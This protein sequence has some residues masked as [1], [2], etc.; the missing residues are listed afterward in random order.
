MHNNYF[1][2]KVYERIKEYLTKENAEAAN[3]RVLKMTITSE[4]AEKIY[5]YIEDENL[6]TYSQYKKNGR[7]VK[8]SYTPKFSVKMY[9]KKDGSYSMCLIDSGTRGRYPIRFTHLTKEYD[10]K[11]KKSMSM[12]DLYFAIIKKYPNHLISI[13]FAT[14]EQF[15]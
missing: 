3:F 7:S 15:S 8:F 9:F 1:L 5:K 4:V 14:G 2:P 13:Q 11:Y 6:E 12:L 10:E